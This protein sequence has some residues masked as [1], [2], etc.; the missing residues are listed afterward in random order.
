MILCVNT[1][2]PFSVNKVIFVTVKVL[3][4]LWGKVKSKE[5]PLPSC[6]RQG[7]RIYS[8]YSFLT[9]A[10]DGGECSASR[11][12]RALSPG[13]EPPSP[14]VQKAGRAS[15]LVW[16]QR[17]E[18]KSFPSAGDRKLVVQ[19]VVTHYTDLATP[20]V[21]FEV[22]TEFLNNIYMS[23]C[24]KSFETRQSHESREVNA[25]THMKYIP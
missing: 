8:T 7:E 10:L 16:T 3:C 5:I 24:F 13:K 9:S 20:A 12:G 4:L 18:E 2:Y 22:R 23:F 19:S 14:I 25:E 21:Y 1:D 15:E 11:P 17:V 6:R